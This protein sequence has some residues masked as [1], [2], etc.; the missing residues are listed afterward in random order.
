MYI[1]IYNYK[2]IMHMHNMHYHYLKA[3]F[4]FFLNLLEELKDPEISLP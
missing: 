2:Y 1:C 3:L 4:L